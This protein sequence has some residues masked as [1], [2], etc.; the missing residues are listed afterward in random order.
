MV[1]W[2]LMEKSLVIQS[3]PDPCV[4]T[5]LCFIKEKYAYH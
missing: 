3:L 2:T 1:S 4:I 5:T